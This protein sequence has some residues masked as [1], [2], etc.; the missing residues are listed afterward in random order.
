MEPRK[1]FPVETVAHTVSQSLTA[2]LSLAQTSAQRTQPPLQWI[3]SAAPDA[4]LPLDVTL[5]AVQSLLAEEKPGSPEEESAAP[6][7]SNA[8]M[9]PLEEESATEMMTHTADQVTPQATTARSM[10]PQEE[11]ESTTLQSDSAEEDL[12]IS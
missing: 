6:S 12:A 4:T 2:A 8:T 1:L 11:E 10:F 7:A 9:T 3:W 5:C